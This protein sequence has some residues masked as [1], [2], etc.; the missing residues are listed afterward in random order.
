MPLPVMFHAG[1]MA[2]AF[3]K[4]DCA[5]ARAVLDAPI[6]WPEHRCKE[7]DGLGGDPWIVGV[8]MLG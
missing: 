1:Q 8:G 6:G 3:C 5:A 4:L 2:D 7:P